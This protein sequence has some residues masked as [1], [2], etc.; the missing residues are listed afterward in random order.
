MNEVT[1]NNIQSKSEFL[2]TPEGKSLFGSD[3]AIVWFERKYRK[4]LV[5]AG[6]L[7]KLRGK[8]HRLRPDYDFVVIQIAKTIARQ[9]VSSNTQAASINKNG[10]GDAV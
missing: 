1:L 2:K 9:S 5:D 4:I 3:N 8:W 6:V 10:M 7:I